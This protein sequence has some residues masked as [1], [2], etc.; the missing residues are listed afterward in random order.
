M[1]FS[2]GFLKD[3]KGKFMSECFFFGAWFFILYDVLMQ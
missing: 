1:Q 2:G 3:G